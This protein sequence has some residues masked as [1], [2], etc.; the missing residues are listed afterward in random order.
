MALPSG[1]INVQCTT[2]DDKPRLRI[3][4]GKTVVVAQCVYCGD[5]KSATKYEAT[6]KGIHNPHANGAEGLLIKGE[7]DIDPASV[8]VHA[9]GDFIAVSELKPGSIYITTPSV[10]F[11]FRP[12][13]KPER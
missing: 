3:S 8:I 11:E 6:K 1:A 7:I 12:K 4:V 10:K 5:G 2:K 13:P 9:D